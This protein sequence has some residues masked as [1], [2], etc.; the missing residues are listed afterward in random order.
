MRTFNKHSPNFVPRL[1]FFPPSVPQV[2]SETKRNHGF[3]FLFL[4]E[5][6]S[7]SLGRSSHGKK[8]SSDLMK[9]SAW[10]GFL[11]SWQGGK[12]LTKIFS[13]RRYAV[14]SS[15]FAGCSSTPG[16]HRLSGFRINSCNTS[17]VT[18]ARSGPS[19]VQ[20]K[21][22][23]GFPLIL[24]EHWAQTPN[25]CSLLERHLPFLCSRY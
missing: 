21:P 9:S 14:P 2:L 22:Q 12:P 25:K 18:T 24:K 7:A 11:P 10:P 6:D 23:E 13:L 15:T 19:P 1:D 3:P 4:G 5:K 16:K 17:T 20:V 8:I